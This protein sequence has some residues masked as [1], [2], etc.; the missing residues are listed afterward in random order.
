MTVPNLTGIAEAGEAGTTNGNG[1]GFAV[2]YGTKDTANTTGTTTATVLSSSESYMTLALK[3]PAVSGSP[4]GSLTL[5]G[6]G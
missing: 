6:V 4:A 1:G 5:L 3:P 2:A